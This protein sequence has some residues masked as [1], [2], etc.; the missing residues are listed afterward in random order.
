MPATVV[1]DLREIDF[2]AF[3]GMTYEDAKALASIKPI[4]DEIRRREAEGT[5]P[6]VLVARSDR[7]P[8]KQTQK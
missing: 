6:S 5:L 3:E 8:R 4:G 2:G 1:P 7:R